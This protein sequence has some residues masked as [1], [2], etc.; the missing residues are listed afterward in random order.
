M[1]VVVFVLIIIILIVIVVIMFV[2]EIVLMVVS[3][4]VIIFKLIFNIQ[5]LSTPGLIISFGVILSMEKGKRG[6]PPTK[7][8]LR[9]GGSRVLSWPDRTAP[10]LAAKSTAAAAPGCV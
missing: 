1:I 10:F 6:V 3:I 5:D 2:A 7:F 8:D 9:P 4:E